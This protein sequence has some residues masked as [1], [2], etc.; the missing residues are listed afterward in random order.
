LKP[1]PPRRVDPGL[2]LGRV[3]E[4]IG[5]EKTRC[6]SIDPARPGQK[7]GCN[8]LIFFLLK[9]RCFDFKKIDPSDPVKTRALNWA[10]SENYALAISLKIII[11]SILFKIKSHAYFKKIIEI[12]IL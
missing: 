10:G 9:R 5:E 8:P 2:E 12:K 4:K 3:K 7:P 1:G 11:T 6:D